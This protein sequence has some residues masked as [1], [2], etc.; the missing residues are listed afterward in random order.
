MYKIFSKDWF[1]NLESRL[2]EMGLDSDD[3]SF[4]ERK[5]IVINRTGG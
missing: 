2:R 5:N 3:K 4:D 1:F